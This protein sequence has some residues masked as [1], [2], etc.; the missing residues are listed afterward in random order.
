M[1]WSH[2]VTEIEGRPVQI[3]IDD[4]FHSS[5]PI[6]ELPNLAWFG[7]YCRNPT[8]ASFWDPDEAAVLDAIEDK[9]IQLCDQFGRGWSAYV[10]RIATRG[11]RE[12]FIYFGDIANIDDV[13]PILRAAHSNYRIDYD[14]TRDAAWKRYLSCLPRE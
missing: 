4:S 5:A 14:L 1:P 2:R 13:L 3:L 6:E 12:Y 10:M 8:D 9:L 11:I 7:V